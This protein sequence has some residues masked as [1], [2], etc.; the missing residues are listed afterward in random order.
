M[1]S[2]IALKHK[3]I[4]TGVGLKTVWVQVGLDQV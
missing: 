4:T 3:H 2:T 1:A